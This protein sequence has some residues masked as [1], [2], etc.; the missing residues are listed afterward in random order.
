MNRKTIAVLSLCA[1]SLPLFAG[2]DSISFSPGESQAI[3]VASASASLSG[4]PTNQCMNDPNDTTTFRAG[5]TVIVYGVSTSGGDQFFLDTGTAVLAGGQQADG[6]FSFS[7]KE[8]KINNVGMNTTIT[9][10]KTTTVTMN[11]AGDSVDGKS[12]TTNATTCSG[13]CNGIDPTNCTST[14][15]FVGVA[16][17]S[18]ADAPK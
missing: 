14:S 18:A 11:L 6:S 15:T 3:R 1:V 7:G 13:S 5:A 9:N 17:D 12:V 8:V 10:T 16:L 2:C 4:T